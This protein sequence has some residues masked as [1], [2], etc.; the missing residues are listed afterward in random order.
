MTEKEFEEKQLHQLLIDLKDIDNYKKFINGSFIYNLGYYQG[1]LLVNEIDRLN[2]IINELEQ[3]LERQSGDISYAYKH[4]LDK[5][6]ELRGNSSVE[7]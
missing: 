5:L 6:K 4:T 1:L 2:N 7:D 3:W